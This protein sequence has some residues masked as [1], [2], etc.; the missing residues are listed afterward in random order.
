MNND[1]IFLPLI[2][3]PILNVELI[4][5]THVVIFSSGLTWD[6]IL[7]P[8]LLIQFKTNFDKRNQ[9]LLCETS[10]SQIFQIKM[11]RLNS[12]YIS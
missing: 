6:R 7:I 3:P 10:P 2:N 9:M 11:L 5:A 12:T 4:G 8:Y 1:C